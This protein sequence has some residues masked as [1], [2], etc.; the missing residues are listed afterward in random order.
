MQIYG[1]LQ[2]CLFDVMSLALCIIDLFL[3]IGAV[4][5]IIYSSNQLLE[6]IQLPGH[7]TGVFLEDFSCNISP[8]HPPT[9]ADFEENCCVVSICE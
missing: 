3:R 2:D 5:A 7:V 8:F 1:H 4:V 6:A 9:F